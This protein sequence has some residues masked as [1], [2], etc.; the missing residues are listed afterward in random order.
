LI[1]DM[2]RYSQILEVCIAID[3]KPHILWSRSTPP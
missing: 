3:K 1:D 2:W